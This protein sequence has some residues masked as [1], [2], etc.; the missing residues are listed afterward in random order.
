MLAAFLDINGS[1]MFIDI[2]CH[3]GLN[4]SK[5]TM[6]FMPVMSVLHHEVFYLLF[7]A[8]NDCNLKRNG[9]NLFLV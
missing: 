9:R 8:L 1:V 5:I 2:A 3:V 4:Q 7:A 6:V